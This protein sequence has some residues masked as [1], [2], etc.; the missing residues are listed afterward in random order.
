MELGISKR[1]NT[2]EGG[3][4]GPGRKYITETLDVMVGS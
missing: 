4:T 1:T 2:V 3:N